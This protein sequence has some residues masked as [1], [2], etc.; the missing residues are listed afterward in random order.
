MPV[1]LAGE[2]QTTSPAGCPRLDLL[3]AEPA[4]A[5]GVQA[6]DGLR[7]ESLDVVLGGLKHLDGVRIFL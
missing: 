4:A 2:N 1:F 7:A 3:H 5:L 6:I